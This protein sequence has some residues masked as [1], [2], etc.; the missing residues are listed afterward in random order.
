MTVDEILK[1]APLAL[2]AVSSAVRRLPAIA[3]AA[4]GRHE[5]PG[6]VGSGIRVTACR[7]KPPWSAS[8][9]R[10]LRGDADTSTVRRL[11]FALAGSG[12]LVTVLA[13]DRYLAAARVLRL[14]I[15]S[16]VV[17]T[18]LA[19]GLLA[20]AVRMLWS[21]R[22]NETQ[23]TAAA[24]QSGSLVVRGAHED[25]LQYSLGALRNVGA[26][27]VSIERAGYEIHAATG[28]RVI[29]SLYLGEYMA[30]TIDELDEEMTEIRVR[31]LKLDYVT[32]SRSRINI[33]NFLECW[34]FYP[35]KS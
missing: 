23:Y 31:S 26:Q 6:G 14:P 32:P 7:I 1:F 28:L 11:S 34:A 10:R 15:W 25:I 33:A 29:S 24:E 19:I 18:A 8:L 35:A 27:I 22:V 4:R 30:V 17:A 5:V 13:Y 20:S 21:L 12:A 9:D 2:G 3:T 16:V